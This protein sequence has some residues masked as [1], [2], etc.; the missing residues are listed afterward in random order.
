MM[1][2]ATLTISA[3]NRSR[4]TKL[5]PEGTIVGRSASCDVVIDC[6]DV[7]RQHARV[8]QDPFGR[9]IVEDLGSSNGTFVS[10]VRVHESAILPGETVAIG[11][12]LLS[13]DEATDARVDADASIEASN[14]VV[15]DFGMEV[16]Y[17]Q[18]ELGDFSAR[19]CPDILDDIA[20]RL[21][22]VK[23][24]PALYPEVCRCLARAPRTAAAV[25]RVPEKGTPIPEMPEVLACH[26]GTSPDDT[27]KQVASD[28][29]P[30]HL[31]F[32]V[33]HR[34]LD[35][36][37]SRDK[38]VMA[39]SV[40]SPDSKVTITLVDEHSP[41]ATICAPL[42]AA[43][44]EIDLLYV[45]VPIE[46]GF[47][48]GPEEMFALVCLVAQKVAS[49]RKSLAPIHA[50]SERRALDHELALAHQLQT[51]LTPRLPPDLGQVEA[52]VVYRPVIWVG[53]DFCD[54]WKLEDGRLAFALGH[55]LDKGLPA[56]IGISNLRV[57]LRTTLSLSGEVSDVL[58]RVNSHLIGSCPDPISASLFLGLFDSST[59]VLDY[60]NVGHPEPIIA[61]PRIGFKSLGS[62]EKALL[63]SADLQVP[64][65]HEP[66]PQGATTV[67]V[68]GGI[69][70]ARAPDKDKFGLGRL[71][72][73]LR[74]T[75]GRSARE[76]A[77][78]VL[79]AVKDFQQAIAQTDD[80]SIFV[81]SRR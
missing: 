1:P 2:E 15:K 44:G 30:S 71:T 50:R 66:I 25:L 57:L 38:A 55:V 61:N 51:R 67:A 69:L 3:G 75:A 21:S 11:P 14:I 77:D 58:K 20:G 17:A 54:V 79:K 31:A 56:A 32:R 60:V 64:A 35:A 6:A 53:G 48:A 9:W 42:G 59:S 47:Q 41:R 39:K 18:E 49:A 68:S 4:Q 26:F 37:R 8:F 80:F 33:S 5:N 65:R 24:L 70:E 28:S 16:F 72:N 29:Y 22:Q 40:Y 76:V 81:F 52:A 73:V 23:D 78:S 63:G 62:S 10:G 7:S 74:M 45:D 46:E 34:V 13:I 19:P 27:V 12:A 36:A 43:A